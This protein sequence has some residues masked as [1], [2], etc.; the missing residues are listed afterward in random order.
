[1]NKNWI[2]GLVMLLLVSTL[3]WAECTPGITSLT[4]SLWG[5]EWISSCSPSVANVQ[6][7]P[8]VEK[9][10]LGTNF[11]VRLVTSACAD[12]DKSG[13]SLYLWSAVNPNT[14]KWTWWN[15][16][17]VLESTQN[18]KLKSIHNKCGTNIACIREQMNAI[19]D[20][21][22]ARVQIY[23]GDSN[24]QD[25]GWTDYQS[26]VDSFY[27]DTDNFNIN[28]TGTYSMKVW[29][30]ST[31]VGQYWYYPGEETQITAQYTK[32]VNF[33]VVSVDG[34]NYGNC[35]T[36]SLENLTDQELGV[37]GIKSIFDGFGNTW[38]SNII[39]LILMVGVAAGLLFTLSKGSRYGS[40]WLYGIIFF[41]E[42]LLS[43]IGVW[44]DAL[45]PI[46]LVIIGLAVIIPLTF[47][48]ASWMRG[49]DGE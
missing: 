4:G 44:I 40:G 28:K 33:T 14:G 6:I 10:Q 39:Y 2:I 47:K 8:C 34:D 32:V 18:S 1:M 31:G 29:I 22:S 36:N 17:D 20:N 16:V 12:A 37:A 38:T 7:D 23:Y 35:T 15:F 26:P 21:V 48:I 13:Y 27:W 46:F 45:S 19:C 24:E 41:V 25:T 11:D 3:V 5:G 43:L 49:K 42:G 30:T 9:M